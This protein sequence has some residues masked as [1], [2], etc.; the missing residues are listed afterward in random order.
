MTLPIELER[1][2]DERWYGFIDELPGV[3]ASGDSPDEAAAA[4]RALALRV[5]AERIEQGTA[6]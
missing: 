3:M 4:T 1:E 2:D 5:L 6:P